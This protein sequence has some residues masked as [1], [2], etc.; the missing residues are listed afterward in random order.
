LIKDKLE[1]NLST[2]PLFDTKLF[3]KNIESAY[4]QIYDRSQKGQEPDHIYV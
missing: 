2:A 1:I 3:T 4:K